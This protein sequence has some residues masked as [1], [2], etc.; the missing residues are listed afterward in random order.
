MI[1][2]EGCGVETNDLNKTQAEQE[3]KRPKDMDPQDL[4]QVTAFQDEK[5]R[6]FMVSTKEEEPGYYL[7]EGKSK[8]FQMLFPANGKYMERLSSYKNENEES[9]GFHNFDEN[10]NIEYYIQLSYYNGHNFVSEVDRMLDIVSGKNGYTGDYQKETVL[11]REIYSSN[12]INTLDNVEIKYNY[13]YN[14]FGFIKPTNKENEGLEYSIIF[15]C[16]YDDRSCSLDEESAQ[17]IV[18][19]FINSIQFIRKA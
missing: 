14:Y 18:N 16:K 3:Q 2:L 6:E 12:K 10:T 9:V 11:D 13:G 8:K 7:I 15:H 17:K 19:K 1:L 5:T 4:P